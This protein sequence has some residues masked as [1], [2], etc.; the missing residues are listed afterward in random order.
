MR[1]SHKLTSG[2]LGIA[3]IMAA[4][5]AF[6]TFKS[7][8]LKRDAEIIVNSNLNEIIG[9]TEIAC[10]TERV[11]AHFIDWFFHL[12]HEN[13]KETVELEAA[14][15]KDFAMIHEQRLLWENAIFF[16]TRLA[17]DPLESEEEEDEDRL[18]EHLYQSLDRLEKVAAKSLDLCKNAEPQTAYTYYSNFVRALAE[19][20]RKESNVLTANT[21]KELFEEMEEITDLTQQII[22]SEILST[23]AA[24]LLALFMASFGAR[25]ITGP[26]TQLS[27]SATKIGEGDLTTP[28]DTATRDEIGELAC[29][30]ERMREQVK[31]AQALLEN[32]VQE[33]T[34]D[35]EKSRSLAVEMMENAEQLRQHA[36]HANRSKSDFLANMSHE[37][38]TPLNSIIGFSEILIDQTFGN[39]NMK[40]KKY[41]NNVRT[42]GRHLLALINDI[43]DLSKIEAGKME[44]TRT[45][46]NGKTFLNDSMILIRERAHRYG[47]TLQL[48]I[49]APLRDAELDADELKLK[50]IL[51]NL[52]SNAIKFTPSGGSIE[53]NADL[54]DSGLIVSIIDSGIG[55]SPSDQ[56]RV[57]NEFEQVDSSYAKTQQGTGLGL[58]LTRKLVE[59]HGGR[60]ECHSPGKGYGSTFTFNIPQPKPHST[61]HPEV[62][63]EGVR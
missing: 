50:Q 51:L 48:N 14:L 38:R 63:L 1:I 31:G 19:E 56:G 22:I 11:N 29:V 15:T 46:L 41:V 18:V 43:L 57:F 36:E 32:K 59:L 35:V 16:G 34:K 26:L 37:L 40:Q 10:L 61:I 49:S 54:Q 30:F 45:R 21:R 27:H 12:F 42:A 3:L 8:R 62:T 7:I 52:T 47:H 13:E 39:V 23:S 55:I 17:G 9:P 44:L 33:R 2:F 20:I 28:I 60:I 25:S 4:A 5:G 6:A 24:V 58:A 53:V